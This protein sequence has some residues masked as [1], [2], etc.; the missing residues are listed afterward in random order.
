M[1]ADEKFFP[2][3]DI[4]PQQKIVI[5]EL[6]KNENKKYIFLQCGTGTGKSAIAIDI[7]KT[8][9]YGYIITTTK[10]L[11]KQY[12]RDF[13][14]ESFALVKGRNNYVCEYS[15]GELTCDCAPCLTNK[16]IA[17]EC[18]EKEIECPYKE[19]MKK[20]A[21]SSIFCCNYS[22]FLRKSRKSSPRNVVVFDEAHNIENHLVE[23]GSIEITPSEFFN[24]Y[25]N[26][27]ERNQFDSYLKK[28][29]NE[30]RDIAENDSMQQEYFR[31]LNEFYKKVVEPKWTELDS[32]F[33]YALKEAAKTKSY[34]MV[35]TLSKRNDFINR[36]KTKLEYVTDKN[37]TN[38]VIEIKTNY[39]GKKGIYV[40]PL[41]VKELFYDIVY[42]TADKFIFMSATIL[43]YETMAESLG[44]P[45][46]KC[47]FINLESEFEPSRSPIVQICNIDTSYKNMNNPSLPDDIYK[48]IQK[49]IDHH[50][51]EKG[52]IHTGN[53]KITK[54]IYDKFKGNPRF[55]YRRDDITNQDILNVHLNTSEPTILVSSSMIDGVDL[56][57]DL[58]KFQIIVKIP[59]LNLG[60][61]RVKIKAKRNQNWYTLNLWYNIIQECG[62]STRNEFDSSTT[63]VL[64]KNFSREFAAAKSRSILPQQ[65]VKRI[66]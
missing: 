28:I 32:Q 12:D 54:M 1:I 38:F 14:N 18:D 11:Q 51:N 16:A 37:W 34:D 5:N 46:D 15:D 44:L 4:R 45:I 8:L 19:I 3:K 42:P 52:I 59:Y 24:M 30:F 43:D 33:Q 63:Y 58:S 49:I 21:A 39:K 26:K 7:C 61:K 55:L 62:R 66:I 9:G 64:D 56:Y 29:E 53:S 50:A 65:F 23:L 25:L 6:N 35:K 20:A 17:K 2:F 41:E 47:C 36:L 10:Q 13:H 27:S 40:T 48:M 60:N 22:Y 57:D 31:F